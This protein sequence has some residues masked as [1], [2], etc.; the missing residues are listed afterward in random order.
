MRFSPVSPAAWALK[1]MFT[2]IYEKGG[3]EKLC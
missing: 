3:K 1:P 2:W